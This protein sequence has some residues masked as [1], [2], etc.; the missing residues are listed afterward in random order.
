M[1]TLLKIKLT[2]TSVFLI[3]SHKTTSGLPRKTVTELLSN[4]LLLKLILQRFNYQYLHFTRAKST[5]KRRVTTKAPYRYK[6]TRNHYVL[7]RFKYFVNLAIKVKP[8]PLFAGL[9]RVQALKNVFTR[10]DI[11]GLNLKAVRYSISIN[12]DLR[13]KEWVN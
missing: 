4:A 10:L 11:A 7:Q 1:E 9:A 3:N 13:V 5:Q 12:D 8:V 2:Y 6:H